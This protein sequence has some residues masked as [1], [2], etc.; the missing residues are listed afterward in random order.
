MAFD[1]DV[2]IIG[3]GPAGFSCAMQSTKFDKKVLMVEADA[4]NLGGTW[5]NKGTVPSKA[6]RE[7]ADLIQRF[8]SQFGDERGRKPY[9]RFRMEDL[10]LYKKT[11]LENKNKKVKTDLIKN[12]VD[13]ARGVGSVI[14]DHTV[15]VTDKLNNTTRYTTE[16]ILIATGSSPRTPDHISVKSGSVLNYDTILDLTH[17]PRRL[18]IIGSGVITFEYATI[19]SA[20]G[21]RIT[22]LSDTSDILPFLDREIKEHMMQVLRKQNIQ[23]FYD[24]SVEKIDSNNLRTCMEVVFKQTN[25]DRIHV[26]ETDEVLYIGGKT[27]NTDQLGLEDI[28]VDVDDNGFIRI[29]SSLRTSVP[30]VY[31]AG[32]VTGDP[33]SAAASFVQG[34]IAA[35]NMFDMPKESPSESIPYG[36]YS[37]P[38]VS[39]IGLTEQKAEEL[40][41]DVTVGRAYYENLTQ[42]DINHQVDGLLKL[43][44]RTDDLK[45]LG[46]H[47][48]GEHAADL[49]HLGQ[50]IMA[51]NG[52]ITYFIENVL[53]YPT[54]SEAYRIAAFNGV[55]RVY[56]AGVKY[57]KILE[58]GSS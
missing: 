34:R 29:D 4:K 57:K 27:P 33:S 12:E 24:A 30:T 41:I 32:D 16:H 8:H 45:L 37:I 22:I 46:V 39:G 50:S 20:L 40:G 18:V 15:E 2:I 36:V 19:F 58:K 1:Y 55:N 44:F 52:N 17:I 48:I 26:S 14:D 7:A 13:T 9:E 6:L 38:E 47:I 35:C 43:V 49:I 51:Q 53:N 28:Q 56:K 25:S 21:T 5:L 11:I 31:A 42:A 3:S 23:I 54:Y 10:L